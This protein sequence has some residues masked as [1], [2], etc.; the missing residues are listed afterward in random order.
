VKLATLLALVAACDAGKKPAPSSGSGSA[1]AP[2][3]AA[4]ADAHPADALAILDAGTAPD[5][6]LPDVPCT[7]ADIKRVRK[8]ADALVKAGHADQAVAQLEAINCWL[9]EG[10]AAD[11]QEQIAWHISDLAFAQFKAGDPTG[12]YSTAESQTEPYPHNVAEVFGEDSKIVQSLAYNADLCR[13]VVE[14]KRGAFVDPIPCFDGD[15]DSKGI[16]P[17]V[18]GLKAPACFV[19]GPARKNADGDPVCGRLSLKVKGQKT[20]V[21]ALDAGDEVNLADSGVCCNISDVKFGAGQYGFTVLVVSGGRNCE[22]GT[23]STSEEDV[24]EHEGKFLRVAS[25][26]SLRAHYH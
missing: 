8:D 23:A 2:I 6:A 14:K 4:P 10:Q 18:S 25:G 17:E 12:C 21:L 24:Y 11:L 13:K 19:I 26:L 16:P 1:P 3:V 20:Q 22:G 9:E 7:A 5:D 15:S